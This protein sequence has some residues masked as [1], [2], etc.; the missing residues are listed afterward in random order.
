MNRFFFNIILFF[1]IFLLNWWL[2]GILL[3]AG[4]FLFK[5]FYEGL[6]YA[7]FYDLI[8]TVNGLPFYGAYQAVIFSF[9]L[10]VLSEYF[11]KYLK[12]YP[13]NV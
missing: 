2:F 1:S 6:V 9:I 5:N 7:A 3:L 11:K 8:F 4:F 10:L 13:D 12:F